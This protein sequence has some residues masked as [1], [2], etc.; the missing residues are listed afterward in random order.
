MENEKVF[1]DGMIFTHK[2]DGAPDFVLGGISIN[3]DQ[4]VA[5]I[6]KYKKEDGWVNFDMLKGKPK[7][8]GSKPRPYFQLNTWKPE[9]KKVEVDSSGIPF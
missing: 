7:E 1:A 6:Q 4:F 8:D 3:V 5:Q 9:E 2:R